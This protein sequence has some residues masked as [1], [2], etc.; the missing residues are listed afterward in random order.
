MLFIGVSDADHNGDRSRVA[1]RQ[2]AQDGGFPFLNTFSIDEP[3]AHDRVGDELQ[4]VAAPHALLANLF[5][6]RRDRR[7]TGTHDFERQLLR[8]RVL[9]EPSAAQSD[10]RAGC[11]EAASRFLALIVLFCPL[12]TLFEQIEDVRGFVVGERFAVLKP[13]LALVRHEK[14]LEGWSAVGLPRQHLEAQFVRV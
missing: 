11:G 13:L 9:G 12:L 2:K 3:Q 10:K 6:C 14:V 5:S 7:H 8:F 1:A 4:L